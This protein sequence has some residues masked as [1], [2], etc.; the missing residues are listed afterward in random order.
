MNVFYNLAIYLYGFFIHCASFFNEKA[1]LWVKGRKDWEA[2]LKSVLQGSNAVIWFHCAS[3]GE[4]EQGRPLIEKIK[5]KLNNHDKN[6]EIVFKYLDELIG[7]HPV[8]NQLPE[9]GF[10]VGK[11]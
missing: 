11:D 5:L 7:K 8:Q 2:K 3:L 4:F 6:L 10:K 1:A 9:I